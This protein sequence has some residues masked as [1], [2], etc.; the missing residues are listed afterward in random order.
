MISKHH[1]VDLIKTAPTL[2]LLVLQ[3]QHA[4]PQSYNTFVMS[5]PLERKFK[6]LINIK[7]AQIKGNSM[8]K[9]PKPAIY[10]AYKC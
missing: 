1:I 5:T 3:A 8:F 2:V 7:I 9:S 4:R 10:P 6:M